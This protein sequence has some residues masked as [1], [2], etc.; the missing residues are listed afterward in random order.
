MAVTIVDHDDEDQPEW[1]PRAK[2]IAFD[3]G[4]LEM[5]ADRPCVIDVNPSIESSSP[6]SLPSSEPSPQPARR[7]WFGW[8]PNF[9]RKSEQNP[10][11]RPR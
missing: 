1:R 3:G 4:V 8:L 2:V 9:G 5:E 7:R 11:F 6:R 10:G